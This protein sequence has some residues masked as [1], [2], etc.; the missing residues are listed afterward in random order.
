MIH[1]NFDKKK[2]KAARVF[3][4][5]YITVVAQHGFADDLQVSQELAP[6]VFS[7]GLVI[8]EFRLEW[9]AIDNV[10]YVRICNMMGSYVPHGK[11]ADAL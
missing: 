5:A 1:Y 4:D 6:F 7:I 2:V 8:P 9:I 11:D 10:P 3:L